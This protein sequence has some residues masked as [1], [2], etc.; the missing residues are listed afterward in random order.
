V[1]IDVRIARL[2]KDVEEGAP[3]LVGVVAVDVAGVARRPGLT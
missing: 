2:A 1:R 3:L